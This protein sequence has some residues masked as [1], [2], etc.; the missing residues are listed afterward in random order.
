[1]FDHSTADKAVK[2]ESQLILLTINQLMKRVLFIILMLVTFSVHAQKK[3]NP[4]PVT[5][6]SV[7]FDKAWLFT[8]D[9]ASNAERP[10]YNDSQWRKVNLPHD[11]SIED[12]PNQT[13][14]S[15]IGPFDKNS[16]GSTMTGF[17]VGGTGWYRKKFV[18]AEEQQDKLIY[19]YF[20]GVYMNSD[21]WLNGHHLG[22]HPYGY[23]PFYYDLTPWLKPVGQENVL[24]VM[25]RNEG[26]NARWYS[27][28]GIYRHVWLIT[29]ERVHVAP[30]G[31]YITTPEVSENAAT[32]QVKSKI[33]NE[34]TTQSNINLVTTILSPDGKTVSLT[35]NALTIGANE[36]KT[37][38]QSITLTNPAL[39]SVEFPQLYK[40]VTEIKKGKK[41]IDRFETTFGIRSIHVDATTGLTINGKSVLLKGGSVH[42]DNGPLGS[43]SFDRAEERK[44]EILKSNGFNAI[45]TSHNP[46]SIQLLDACDRL[47]MLVIDEAF[48]AWEK[49]KMPDDYHLYFKEWWKK[50]LEAM[51][52]RDRNHPSVIIWSIGNEVAERADSS[53][54]RITRQLVD[55]IRQLDSTRPVT[56]AFCR[57]W[58]PM[59]FGKKWSDTAPAYALLDIGGYNYMMSEYES[60]HEQFPNRIMAGL[61]S[62]PEKALE[63]WDMVEKNPYI[64]GDFV[65]TAFDYMGEAS[66]GNSTYD[67]VKKIIRTIGW[68]WYISWCG[69]IDIIGN[70][71]PQSY[72]RDVVWHRSPITM[73]VHEL[74][75]EGLLDNTSTWGWPNEL[76]SWTWPGAEGKSLMVRVF[77]RA[78]MVRLKLNGQ[79]VGEQKIE[80]GS[81]TAVFN[82]PYQPGTLEA[83]NVEN[84]KETD[85]IE[86]KTA[87][88]PT[89][90]RLTAD[91]ANI[92]ADRNDLSYV[93][94]EVVDENGQVVP[95]ANIPVQFTISGAGEIAAVGNADPTDVSS[96]QKPERKAFRGRCLVI[97][98]SADKPGTIVLEA[99]ADGLTEGQTE[100]GVK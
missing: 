100:I 2:C 47:G 40:A 80:E 32:V 46:P 77:S 68:P 79:V 84:E 90:I 36:S 48:D 6:R 1:V 70:K 31:V 4:S 21:I 61:E 60:D 97:I 92:S 64:I 53:G 16:K 89:S 41:T 81:I 63:N 74:I 45:R 39:W 88:T 69:D 95:T 86:F 5:S 51:I 27:G 82:L 58:E 76:Q 57:Y 30:W 7:L 44:I 94:V 71:K 49:S 91:R 98:R 9:A 43:A 38:E 34:E 55:A 56:E 23:T 93:M 73:A 67:K 3:N 37:D 18:T 78:P 29:T 83:V 22:N 10:E 96:F 72:Y 25:V 24:A 65:W 99:T 17:T 15:I 75:P 50:D 35:K 52:L 66:L 11:W 42:H 33:N 54:F 20:D 62:Y 14:E 26:R 8:K 12:L 87:G 85:A 13:P 19:I 28:S 59:N